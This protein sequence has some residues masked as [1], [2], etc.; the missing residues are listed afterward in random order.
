VYFVPRVD[1][2]TNVV[3][4]R[5]RHSENEPFRTERRDLSLLL[6]FAENRF[7]RLHN[8]N[9]WV[10]DAV[11]FYLVQSVFEALNVDDRIS[12][13]PVI[14]AA[15][16][17]SDIIRISNCKAPELLTGNLRDIDR[18]LCMRGRD[19]KTEEYQA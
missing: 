15:Q 7:G 10:R 2:P 11:A 16:P 4:D 8:R 9:R 13:L 6:A 5:Q 1:I 3:A 14:V 17:K 19:Y 12:S 18:D